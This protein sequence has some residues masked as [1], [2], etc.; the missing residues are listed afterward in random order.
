[1][2]TKIAKTQI[3]ESL[4]PKS[5][6]QTG[7]NARLPLRDFLLTPIREIVT[8]ES[9]T[10]ETAPPQLIYS[11]LCPFYREMWDSEESGRGLAS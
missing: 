6:A 7:L 5:F 4:T 9:Q 11:E 3:R 8:P 2:K 10:V 1:M